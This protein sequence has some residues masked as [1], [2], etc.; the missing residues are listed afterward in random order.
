[1]INGFAETSVGSIGVDAG[2]WD[3]GKAYF[4]GYVTVR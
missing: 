1:M 3:E 4:V 2:D